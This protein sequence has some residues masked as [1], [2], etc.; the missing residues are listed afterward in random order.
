MLEKDWIFE[1]VAVECYSGYKGEETPR[2]FTYQNRRF[3]ILE[4][5][6]RW[7]EGGMNPTGILH[8]YFKVKSREGEIFLIRYTPS[9]QT[10]TLC[11]KI[12]V[13]NFSNN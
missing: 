4:I 8:S 3:E 10:W 1:E 12:P 6:D 2:S 11:R 5:L 7:Y 9:F 13:P